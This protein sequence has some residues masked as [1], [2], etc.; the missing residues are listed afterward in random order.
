MSTIARSIN[1]QFWSVEDDGKKIAYIQETPN[2][3]TFK[4]TGIILNNN[5][6][7]ERFNTLQDLQRKYKIKF[8]KKIIKNKEILH[9]VFGFETTSKAYNKIFDIRR[10]LPLY[11]KTSKSKSYYCAGYYIIQDKN[12]KI[13]INNPKYILINRFEYNGPFKSEKEALES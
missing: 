3:Y 6:L 1:K 11:T 8:D 5:K 12:K 2:G 9:Q 4:R 10:H 7:L 13:V